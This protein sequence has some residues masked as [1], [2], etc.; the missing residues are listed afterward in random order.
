MLASVLASVLL[1]GLKWAAA[2]VGAGLTV[3]AL[4]DSCV[5]GTMLARL[6]F[7]R[8]GRCD[9][10]AVVNQLREADPARSA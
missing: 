10:D 6:P 1:P 5:M 3:A 9:L 7:N 8:G 4:T 2:L